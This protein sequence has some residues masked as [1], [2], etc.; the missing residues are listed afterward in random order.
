MKRISIW[1]WT[2]A[3]VFLSSFAS[4]DQFNWEVKVLD[5]NSREETTFSLEEGKDWYPGM[6]GTF[7]KYNFRCFSYVAK[8]STSDI[9]GRVLGCK[10]NLE[11]FATIT[12]CHKYQKDSRATLM[13]FENDGDH[14]A[15]VWITCKE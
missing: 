9:K 12:S 8:K 14:V 15:S 2:V 13:I 6:V 11:Q 1:L 10:K 7:N 5:Q 3:S 4:A